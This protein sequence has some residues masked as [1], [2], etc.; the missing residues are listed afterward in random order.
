MSAAGQV[1]RADYYHQ[2]GRAAFSQ[3][4]FDRMSNF[5]KHFVDV[6][7]EEWEA[8][9][10]SLGEKI[11]QSMTHGIGRIQGDSSKFLFQ[12][13]SDSTNSFGANYTQIDGPGF[14]YALAK[15]AG[16]M[17]DGVLKNVRDEPNIG[18]ALVGAARMLSGKTLSDAEA[19]AMME[20]METDDANKLADGLMDQLG[21]KLRAQ[22]T[23]ERWQE[24]ANNRDWDTQN[25]SDSP[26][27]P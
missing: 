20:G 18:N 3:T 5:V 10:D 16:D 24:N 27:E 14:I 25:D 26:K 9:L 8:F 11:I 17:S 13:W 7:F 19:A 2:D 4:V 12:A 23:D 15:W 22:K 1:S 21:E 6:P